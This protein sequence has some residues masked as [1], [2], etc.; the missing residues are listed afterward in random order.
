[1]VFPSS[2]TPPPCARSAPQERDWAFVNETVP[3]EIRGG[4]AGTYFFFW[5]AGY[6]LGPLLFGK[7]V[8]YGQETGAFETFALLLALAALVLLLSGRSLP[9]EHVFAGAAET[10][11]AE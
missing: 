9:D 5:G 11:Q 7:A 6:F 3:E 8:Q 4:I 2:A 10:E 1:M